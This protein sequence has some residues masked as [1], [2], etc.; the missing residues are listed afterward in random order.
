MQALEAK[1][2]LAAKDVEIERLAA[3]VE[4]E[5]AACEEIARGWADRTG[6]IPSH[7]ATA[8][9]DEIAARKKP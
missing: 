9:A 4:A 3:A 1:D 6:I 2:R 5:R 8:I 7:V